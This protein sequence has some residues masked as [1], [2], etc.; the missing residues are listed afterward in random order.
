MNEHDSVVGV[1]RVEAPVV[2]LDREGFID[3]L[4]KTFRPTVYASKKG[5]FRVRYRY[6]FTWSGQS[7]YTECREKMQFTDF[8]TLV[9]SKRIIG[10]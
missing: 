10:F 5:L 9:R 8:V 6:V 3:A 2:H 1:H 4:S 7:Y